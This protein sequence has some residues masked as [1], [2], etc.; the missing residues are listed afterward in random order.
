M[1]TNGNI[2]AISPISER[3]LSN[4]SV[5]LIF[6][7]YKLYLYRFVADSS[8][9]ISSTLHLGSFEVDSSVQ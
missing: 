6:P 2:L 3:E 5:P 1:L 4:T 9:M 7:I 8:P